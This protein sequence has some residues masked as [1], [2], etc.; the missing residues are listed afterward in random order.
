MKRKATLEQQYE[1]AYRAYLRAARA[2][3]A[4]RCDL[5]SITATAVIRSGNVLTRHSLM[6]IDDAVDTNEGPQADTLQGMLDLVLV[7]EVTK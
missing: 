5:K 4:A 1:A 7:T 3:E 2:M 6:V